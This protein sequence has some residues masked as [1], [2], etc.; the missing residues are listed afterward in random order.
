MEEGVILSLN[1]LPSSIASSAAKSSVLFS[2]KWPLKSLLIWVTQ[3]V[4][5]S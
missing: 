4:V 2:T 3:W 5:S 1:G